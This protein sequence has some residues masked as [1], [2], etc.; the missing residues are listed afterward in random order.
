MTSF[1]SAT[2]KLNN[3]DQ[4][5][6]AYLQWYFK[7]R[8]ISYPINPFQMLL[9]ENVKFA[10]RDFGNLEGVYIPAEKQDDISIVG[11][12]LNRPITRQRFTA[13]H[14]L[15][16]HFRDSRQQICP[17]GGRKKSAIERFAD[18]FAAGILMPIEELRLQVEN[19]SRNRDIE[20]DDVLEIADYFGVSFE[21]CLY[22]IAY[23]I[24]AISGNTEVAELKKKTNKY[25]PDDRRKE[26]G[27]NNVLLFEGLIDSYGHALCLEPN[28]FMRSVFQNN[29]VY[30]D[31]RIEGIDI[32]MEKAAEIVTDIRL[33]QQ[34]STYCSEE[35]EAFLSIAGHAEMYSD[36]FTMTAPNKCS[37]FDTIALNRK[38][39]SC[40]P[41]PEFGGQLRQNNSLVL[42]AKF[43][44]VDYKDIIKE[45]VKLDMEVKSLYEQREELSIS[46]YI[47]SAVRLHHKLTVIHPFRDGNGRTL[48][49]FFNMLMVRNGLTPVYI[50]VEDK[51]EYLEAL[52]IADIS[53]DYAPLYEFFFK[54]ILSSN[55]DLTR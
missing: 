26:K 42:G 33:Q 11:I 30:N 55:V 31:S 28:E 47:E 18:R 7:D 49:A 45:L 40:F 17:T 54:A 19:H 1:K 29:Y 14:E 8:Q 44:T 38:L 41:Y 9:D 43:E 52:A 32:D 12:N 21:S 51:R 50:K 5:A 6:N 16:H 4:L 23:D 20:F 25:K 48:R 27:L 53:S 37:V 34:S 46:S 2:P 22:S 10:I 24:H 3:A 13:A 36:I 35:N 15:C 39:F